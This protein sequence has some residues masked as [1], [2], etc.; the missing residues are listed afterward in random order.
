MMSLVQDSVSQA[1][2]LIAENCRSPFLACKMQKKLN[3]VKFRQQHESMDD[4]LK[5]TLECSGREVKDVLY[6]YESTLEYEQL[7]V[8]L[9]LGML[10]TKYNNEMRTLI[11]CNLTTWIGY[12][13][14]II[15]FRNGIYSAENSS[16][17]SSCRKNKERIPQGEEKLER[18][19][20]GR[21]LDLILRRKKLEFGAGE[22]GKQTDDTD[23]KLLQERDLKLPKALKDMMMSLKN[24]RGSADGL[25]VVGLLQYGKFLWF[26]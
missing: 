6:M 20:M 9:K 5:W 11:E 2:E 14:V 19:K 24:E 25:R 21:R 22:A 13:T 1:L 26:L 17:A 15:Q 4:D 18:K 7:I 10:L 16:L 8:L 3:L 23:T 12:V